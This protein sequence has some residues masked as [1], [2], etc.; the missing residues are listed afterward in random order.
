MSENGVEEALSPDAEEQLLLEQKG[1]L[2][3]ELTALLNAENKSTACERI[4]SSVFQRQI[5]DNFLQYN[6]DGDGEVKN[7]YHSSIPTVSG[8]NKEGCCVVL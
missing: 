1:K 6:D 5:Q 2:E 8:S 4:C 3:E 7:P